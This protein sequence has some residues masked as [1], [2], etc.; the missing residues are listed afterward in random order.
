ML[1]LK[2]IALPLNSFSLV[3]KVGYLLDPTKAQEFGGCEGEGLLKRTTLGSRS[4][5]DTW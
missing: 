1:S 3:A 5:T 4:M 2:R